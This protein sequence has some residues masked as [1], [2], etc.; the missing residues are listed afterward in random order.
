[1]LAFGEEGAA[2]ELCSEATDAIAPNGCFA[3]EQKAP[4]QPCGSRD[5]TDGGD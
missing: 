1:M 5:S 4:A 2:E 3:D